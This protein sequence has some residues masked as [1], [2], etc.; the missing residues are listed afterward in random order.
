QTFGLQARGLMLNVAE[1][2]GEEFPSFR[3]FWIERPGI[4]ATNL[5]IHAL[6]DSDSV[7]GLYRFALRPGDITVCDVEV[8]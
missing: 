8:T 1:A 4:G 6:L 7:T 5:V 2:Q 3:A